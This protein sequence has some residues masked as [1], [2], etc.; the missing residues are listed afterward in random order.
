MSDFKYPP[1]YTPMTATDWQKV[2]GEW[3]YKKLGFYPVE[4]RG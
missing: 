2:Y 4:S 1:G 3:F